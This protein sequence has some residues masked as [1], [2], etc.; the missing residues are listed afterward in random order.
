MHVYADYY[1]VHIMHISTINPLMSIYR[2]GVKFN[3]KLWF[4]ISIA[5]RVKLNY[6]AHFV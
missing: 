4:N 2:D 1:Y 3:P 5:P 6:D